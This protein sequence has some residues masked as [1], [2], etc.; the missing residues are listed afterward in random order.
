MKKFREI[1]LVVLMIAIVGIPRL[2]G[3][4][5]FTSIDEPYWLYESANFYYALGQRE[6]ENT[7]YAHHPAVTT[8]WIITAGMLAY[9]P[10]YRA[11]GQGYLKQGKYNIFLAEHGKT[12]LEL[13]IVSRTIQ[14]A[15]IVALFL[16]V[17]LLLRRLFDTR[18]AFFTTVLISVSPF[19]LGQS[20]LLNHEALLCLFLLISLAS[21]LVY[22]Y[23]H[24]IGILLILSAAAAALAQLTKSSGLPLLPIMVLVL[25]VYGLGLQ[26][27]SPRQKLLDTA[28]T[29]GI[30][31]TGLIFF[32]F[33]FWPGMWVAPGKMLYEVYGN[34]LSYTFVGMNLEV[35]PGLNPTSFRIGSLIDGLHIYL[36]DLVWR[37]TVVSWLGFLAGILIV[38]ANF[39]RKI[40]KN[41]QLVILYSLILAV[42]FVFMFSIQLGRKPPHYITTSYL[43]LDLIAGL[44]ISRLVDYLAHRFPGFIKVWTTWLMLSILLA[45]QL[46]SAVGFYPYYITYYN[47]VLEGLQAQV[48]APVLNETGYGVGLDQAAEYLSKKPGAGEMTVMAANGYGSFSYY[49]PGRTVPMN[50]LDL[51]D[52]VIVEI[53]RG[54]QYAVVDYY[55]QKRAGVLTGLEGIEP[56]K[57]IWIS[58][59]EFLHIYRA[60]DILNRLDTTSP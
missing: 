41:Y 14:V 20:R 21:M 46:I 31:L 3:I 10:E 24:R 51:T 57:I 11:L 50:N 32:Y 49:F 15:I 36:I 26:Q 13:L 42:S 27:G 2:V 7:I 47:P 33:L 6:F 58:G 28:K 8:M 18:S 38:V 60:D 34:A 37:T 54:S 44:G 12:P 22:L 56:E 30:W 43:S 19:F 40:D 48:Q 39:R 29:F 59:I 45:F 1:I 23:V 25:L 5:K 53:L 16:V 52:P 9:F 35:L 55:N 17:Y 4:G